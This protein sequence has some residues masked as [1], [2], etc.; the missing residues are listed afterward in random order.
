MEFLFWWNLIFTSL[1]LSLIIVVIIGFLG[2]LLRIPII[3]IFVQGIRNQVSEVG[4]ISFLKN[5]TM[6]WFVSQSFILCGSY[7][8]VYSTN[9]SQNTLYLSLSAVLL[10]YFL[11]QKFHKPMARFT[12]NDRIFIYR[13]GRNDINPTKEEFP[14]EK[15][16]TPL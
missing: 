10:G 6:V 1:W 13:G 14:T 8:F 16:V 15:D 3:G 4:W 7:F 11:K 2:I 12:G 9:P 5:R